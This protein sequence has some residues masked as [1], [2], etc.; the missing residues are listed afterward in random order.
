MQPPGPARSPLVA[1]RSSLVPLL[2]GLIPVLRTVTEPEL[3]GQG[4]EL[5]VACDAGLQVEDGDDAAVAAAVSSELQELCREVL[6]TGGDGGAGL[7]RDP[8][9]V[10]QDLAH[11][12]NRELK[13]RA[14]VEPVVRL[15][16]R[17]SEFR[18]VVG[19]KFNDSFCRLGHGVL[20][21]VPRNASNRSDGTFARENFSVVGTGDDIVQNAFEKG[22][23][24]CT[25]AVRQRLSVWMHLHEHEACVGRKGL[26]LHVAN[27]SREK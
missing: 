4:G 15:C 25:R 10:A 27:R 3:G 5:L 16:G 9:F 12:M 18:V 1:A 20:T 11:E 23:D 19:A 2:R 6:E 7:H 21:E 17:K 14:L 24:E 22:R 13:S 8:S 26:A